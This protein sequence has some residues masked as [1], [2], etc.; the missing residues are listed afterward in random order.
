[1]KRAPNAGGS[2]GT[3]KGARAP[4]A[5]WWIRLPLARDAAASDRP[6]ESKLETNSGWLISVCSARFGSLRRFGHR[7]GLTRR[8]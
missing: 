6:P 8:F 1:M 4:A 3:P 2:H 5:A 7:Y